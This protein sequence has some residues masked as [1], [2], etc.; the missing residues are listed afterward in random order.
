MSNQFSKP[1]ASSLT[2]S[3]MNN[4]L[5]DKKFEIPTRFNV[6]NH[7]RNDL[8]NIINKRTCTI[9]M[10]SINLLE[11]RMIKFKKLIFIKLFPILE[12]TF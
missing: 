9:R 11:F 7:N 2:S 12:T 6:N 3:C 8:V 4:Y 1:G 5:F 10:S